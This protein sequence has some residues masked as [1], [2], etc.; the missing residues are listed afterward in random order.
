MHPVASKLS[1]PEP[2]QEQQSVITEQEPIMKSKGRLLLKLIKIAR[3]SL[4]E[5][6]KEQTIPVKLGDYPFQLYSMLENT[7]AQISPKSK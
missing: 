7:L 5:I 6:P 1:F 2:W 4:G 3:H